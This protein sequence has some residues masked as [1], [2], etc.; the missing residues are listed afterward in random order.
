M[1]SLKGDNCYLRALEPEDLEVLY[2]LENDETVWEVSETLAPYSK[3]VLKEYLANSHR[4]IYDVKQLRLAICNYKHRILGFIDLYDFNPR[5][6]RAGIGIVILDK[7]DRNKGVG[8]ESLKLLM[9]YA[10]GV[11]DL[12]QVYANINEDNLA[13]IHLFTRLGFEQV[14]VKR[15]WTYAGGT[16]KNELL[17]Q[18][19]KDVH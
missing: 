1:I 14:G 8:R 13:S 5:N 9:N 2:I 4:D 7:E 11:L 16:Y 6:K 18:R 19:I 17:F 3:F 10:F 15:D 12:H